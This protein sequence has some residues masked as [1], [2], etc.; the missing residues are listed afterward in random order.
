MPENCTFG[1]L[2]RVELSTFIPPIGVS[3]RKMKEGLNRGN[4]HFS[5]YLHDLIEWEGVRISGE[6]SSA[7]G[8][9]NPDVCYMSPDLVNVWDEGSQLD[10]RK[11]IYE[12][13]PSVVER[14]EPDLSVDSFD[15]CLFE[16]PLEKF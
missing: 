12:S 7:S 8:L 4:Y 1:T 9:L 11:V 14:Q 15:F 2:E 13:S 16:K 5:D 6:K 3:K 10:L